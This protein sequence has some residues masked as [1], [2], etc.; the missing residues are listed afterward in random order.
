MQI[1]I[2]EYLENLIAGPDRDKTAIIDHD[3]SWSFAEL[4]ACSKRCAAL[5]I[6]QFD[7][8]NQPVAV[9][10]PKSA[11]VIFA[12]LGIVYSGNIYTNLDVK[13]PIQR[14]K[15]IIDNIAPILIVTSQALAPD[16]EA[17]GVQRKN[18][19]LIEQIYDEAV[20]FVGADLW[21]RLSGVIDTDPLC[22][23]NTSGSTGVPKGVVLNHRSTIDF[24][25]WCF[26]CLKLNGTERIGSLSPFHF[27]IYT[28]ELNLCLARGATMV[29]IPDQMAIFPAKLMDF[30]ASQAISFLFWVP[31]IM[32]N[33]ANQGLLEIGRAS[34]RERVFK[35]V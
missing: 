8:L 25:D 30:L 21:Q 24:M 28:L 11:G 31:S 34:W 13:S 27:D 20:S 16:L 10:L 17:V 2:L 6:G 26:D 18:I 12:N 35:D 15:A 33:I 19:F 32:V 29:L 7:V 23:I 4:D 3:R 14:T 1:N 22:I 5:L 9:Y